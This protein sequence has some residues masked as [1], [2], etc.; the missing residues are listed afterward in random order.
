M[1]RKFKRMRHQAKGARYWFDRLRRSELEHSLLTGCYVMAT[2][3]NVG[4]GVTREGHARGG[5]RFGLY[6]SIWIVGS[7][8]CGDDHPRPS[9]RKPHAGQGGSDLDMENEFQQ[10]IKQRRKLEFHSGLGAK[11]LSIIGARGVVR[12]LQ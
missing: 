5:A 2:E 7:I 4:S 8:L 6:G 9:E 3:P 12:T 1:R 11:G 10:R